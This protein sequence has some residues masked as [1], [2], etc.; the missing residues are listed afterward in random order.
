MR[1]QT[2]T[3]LFL[4]I[5]L[6][7]EAQDGSI[8]S[9]AAVSGQIAESA[10]D[11]GSSKSISIQ[12]MD[13]DTKKRVPF[14]TVDFSSCGH[15]TYESSG[16]GVFS[17]E[18]AAGFSCYVRIAKSGYTDL[19]LLL[20]YDDITGEA[21]TFN[22][23]LSRSP[24]YFSGS[25]KDAANRSLYLDNARVELVSAKDGQ[26]QQV[27]TNRQGKFSL[28][29]QPRTQYKLIVQRDKYKT[30]EKVFQTEGKVRP[31][32]IQNIL[33]TP[34]MTA[35]KPEGY[36][37]GLSVSRKESVYQA[38]KNS[39]PYFSVQVMAKRKGKITL[40][41]YENALGSYGELHMISE[42]GLDKL[43]VGRFQ[44][45]NIAERV[46][47]KIRSHPEFSHA[48]ITQHLPLRKSANGVE[49]TGPRYMVRLASYL[50][51]ELFDP[52]KI[53]DLGHIKSLDKDEWTIMLLEGFSSL[54]EAKFAVEKVK[55][56]GFGSAH[57]VMWS[58]DKLRRVR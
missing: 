1:S 8:V 57:V 3:I 21:K 16:D 14:F 7:V 5:I 22:V 56:V 25:V 58:D 29:L 4:L 54:D 43:K 44:D 36:N 15:P 20:K 6:R 12:V 50:N 47:T 40:Q 23:F 46:L 18:T 31:Y 27:T 45:R 39:E 33:L 2:L 35:L 10:A 11:F 19:D 26:V 51:P 32:I 24:N 55:A 48:F 13:M 52:S 34:M 30:F 41:E 37:T 17:V 38:K 53:A 9:Q 42:G 28:Y 49:L